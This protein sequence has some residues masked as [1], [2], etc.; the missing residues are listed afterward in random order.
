MSI[1]EV[2]IISGKGGTGKT[3]L[4]ASLAAVAEERKVLADADVDAPNLA[5]LLHPGETHREPFSGMSIADAD[6]AR[7]TGC[8]ICESACRYDAIHVRNGKAVVDEG[9]CEG[10]R[11]CLHVCPEQCISLKSIERGTIRRGD[12]VLGPLWHARLNP[13][14]ENTGLMVALLRKEARKEAKAAGASLII[15]DGPPGIGCPVTSSVTGADFAVIVSEPSRSAL[16][17]LRR[18]AELCGIL[19]VPFGIVIN[20]WNLSEE[21]TETVK[22]AC[23]TERWPLLGMI[24]FDERIAEAVGAGRIPAAEMRDALPEIWHSIRKTGRLEK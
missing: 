7:C 24:P 8:G 16:S 12:T 19:T 1:R 9:F 13:G 21:L 23:R 5:L 2:V 15:T 17:D 20:R 4:T 22:E 10:C 14:G 11:V 18:A 3:T 6:R